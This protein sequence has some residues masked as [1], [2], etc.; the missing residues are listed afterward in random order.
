MTTA[1]APASLK[2]KKT[3][4][5]GIERKLLNGAKKNWPDWLRTV[6][7]IGIA[8]IAGLYAADQRVNALD[9]RVALIEANRFTAADG[10]TVWESLAR[11][12]ERNTA[13]FQRLERIEKSL[14]NIEHALISKGEL[15]P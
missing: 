5:G 14:Q 7:Y 3:S 15:N 2:T 11:L 8:V 12:Q 9:T 6:A 4:R 10:T 13:L 1:K